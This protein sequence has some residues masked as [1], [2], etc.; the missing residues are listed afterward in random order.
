MRHYQI[1][2]TKSH[3]DLEEPQY[4]EPLRSR[5]NNAVTTEDKRRIGKMF[6]RVR[7]KWLS[8]LKQLRFQEEAMT[9]GRSDRT[10]SGIASWLEN[11]AGEKTFATYFWPKICEEYFGGLYTSDIEG[12]HEQLARLQS[13]ESFIS[14]A[15]LDGTY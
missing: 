4:L 7:R 15:K 11:S 8:R 2:E 14:A 5:M 10:L 13:L 1:S 3:T 12:P 9:Q 6:Y